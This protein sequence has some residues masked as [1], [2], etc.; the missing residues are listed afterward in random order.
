MKLK[1]KVAIITGASRGIGKAIALAFANEGAD[2]VI[3]SRSLPEVTETAAQVKALGRCVLA[4]KV[5]VSSKEEVAYMVSSAIGEFGKVDILVNNAGIQN[6]IGLLA[7]NDTEHW[8]EAININ[9]IGTFL[10][11]K[12]VLPIMLR[13]Q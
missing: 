9:L 13:Q 10:C 6:P 1:D 12:A 11:T 8:I 5:D 4:L 2:M 7:E 3:V